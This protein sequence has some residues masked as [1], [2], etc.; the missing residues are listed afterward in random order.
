MPYSGSRDSPSSYFYY[1]ALH[2][3][4]IAGWVKGSEAVALDCTSARQLGRLR[5]LATLTLFGLDH[6]YQ[7]ISLASF[8]CRHG[9]F[10]WRQYTFPEI[11]VSISLQYREE[12]F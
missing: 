12:I 4:G 9:W 2:L 8:F 3:S 5:V 6:P 11:E 10:A 7:A 1:G